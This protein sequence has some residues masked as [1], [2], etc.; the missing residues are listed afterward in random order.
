MTKTMIKKSLR[1]YIS[2]NDKVFLD[3]E[4]I[5]LSKY[6]RIEQ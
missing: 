6:V 1:A 2:I 4:D 5:S 3:P